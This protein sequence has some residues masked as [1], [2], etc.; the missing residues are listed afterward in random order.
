MPIS[1]SDN[2]KLN[3]NLP[4]DERIVA[5]N[6]SDR[7]NIEYKYDGLQ[8]FQLDNRVTYT[9]NASASTWTDSESNVTGIGTVNYVPKWTALGLTDSSIISSPLAF[10]EQ[11]QKVGIGSAPLEAFQ[12][13]G[14]YTTA[15]L[16]TSSMPFVIHKGVNTILGEN[17]YYNLSLGAD[18]VFNNNFAS[19]YISFKNGGFEFRGRTAGSVNTMNQLMVVNGD[20]SV[21][22]YNYITMPGMTGLTASPEGSFYYDGSRFRV[23]ENGYNRTISRLYDVYTISLSQSSTSAPTQKLLESTIGLGTWSYGSTGVYNLTVTNGFVGTSPRINGFCGPFS[24]RS[25]FFGEKINNNTYQIR[26]LDSAAGTHSNNL[27]TDKFL[28]IRIYYP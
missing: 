22:F 16:G 28:E 1:I 5:S 24:S 13:D 21:N 4:I 17:W 12:V 18:Q 27:L 7:N 10:N 3:S 25:V 9:W 11:V 23:R 26:T 8:V 2:F 6:S 15:A 14:N 19:S 20:K